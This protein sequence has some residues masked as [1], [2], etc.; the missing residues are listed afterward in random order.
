MCS[1]RTGM[2][3]LKMIS[4]ASV[5]GFVRTP[6]CNLFMQQPSSQ[7]FS[8]I[9]RTNDHPCGSWKSTCLAQPHSHSQ[10][11]PVEKGTAPWGQRPLSARCHNKHITV[12]RARMKHNVWTS[13]PG[14]WAPVRDWQD[15]IKTGG[16]LLLAGMAVAIWVKDKNTT[17]E[18]PQTQ[19][20]TVIVLFA[21]SHVTNTHIRW[22]NMSWHFGKYVYSRVRW[23][24]WYG[25]LVR[26]AELSTKTGRARLCL[27][28]ALWLPGV[29]VRL[30]GVSCAEKFPGT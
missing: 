23:K 14:I 9:P 30:S 8:C 15:L 28:Q 22:I 29:T 2:I 13:Q 27:G 21:M 24:D 5:K 16:D 3:C 4:L 18:P 25:W 26:L 10:C 1:Q 6:K 19:N 12:F 20:S 11:R 17:T 7:S